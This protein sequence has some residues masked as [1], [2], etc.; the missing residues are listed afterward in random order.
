MSWDL[1]QSYL[2]NACELRE[3]QHLELLGNRDPAISRQSIQFSE[4]V[5]ISER[6]LDHLSVIEQGNK[7]LSKLEI[8]R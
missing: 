6:V 1:Q 7:V 2:G 8:F 3:F 5:R 4:T